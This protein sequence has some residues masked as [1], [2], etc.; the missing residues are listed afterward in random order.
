M[1]RRSGCRTS[2][3]SRPT[4][5]PTAP[6]SSL[7]NPL[8]VFQWGDYGVVPGQRLRY[9]AYA[10]HGTPAALRLSRS[11]AEVEV[12]T[13]DVDDGAHGIQFNRGVA[14]S[15]AYARKFGTASPLAVPEAQRWLSRGLEEGLLGFI[16][17]AADGGYGLRG[18]L[19]E[20]FHPPVLEALR[21]A[22]LRGAD[23]ALVVSCPAEKRGWPDHPSWENAEAM[24]AVEPLKPR[25]PFLRLVTARRNTGS[26]IAHNKFLVLTKAGRPVAVWTGS[27][28]IT[29]GAIF[30]HSN[31]GHV[32]SDARVAQQFLDYWLELAKDPERSALAAWTEAQ[33]PVPVVSPQAPAIPHGTSAIFSPRPDL[34][35]LARYVELVSVGAHQSLFMTAPFG[36]SAPFEPALT[37]RSDV[38]RYVL[39]DKPG[40]DYELRRADPRLNITAG[41]FLGEPGGYRQFIEEQLTGLNSWV[42]FIHTKFMLV[43]PLTADPVVVTGSANFSEASTDENDENMLVIS[44]D[45]RVA[46]IYLTEF[47]RL[48]THLRFRAA[49]RA[50]ADDQRAPDP[51]EPEID[52]HK[53]LKTTDAWT[54]P[55]LADDGAKGRERRLF[56]GQM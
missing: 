51:N 36:V 52:A 23:V 12:T 29:P 49:V 1:A 7:E 41:A 9:R 17:R 31:V 55:Y 2:S 22:A 24:R 20:F 27:T 30:G 45:T 13:E 37:A 16:G 38:V 8:Q 35:A 18:A 28:N 44:G 40:N 42:Q 46:D 10:V 32:V 21:A 15:Q 4:I 6:T 14:G 3:A 48:F 33:T 53:H 5:A 50:H 11:P 39:L 26:G 47:M 34:Q 54:R 43:D 19:Y 56:S 25:Q